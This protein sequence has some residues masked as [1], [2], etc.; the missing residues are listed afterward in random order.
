[1]RLARGSG[2]LLG[3]FAIRRAGRKAGRRAGRQAGSPTCRSHKANHASCPLQPTNYLPTSTALHSLPVASLLP[4]RSPTACRRL[5]YHPVLPVGLGC[6][7]RAPRHRRLG[8]QCGC[9][10]GGL[11]RLLLAWAVAAGAGCWAWPAAWQSWHAPC[12]SATPRF[13]PVLSSSRQC[14][15]ILHTSLCTLLLLLFAS[16][17]HPDLK[18]NTSQ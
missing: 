3:A 4:S 1:V 16:C 17:S 12:H 8:G 14:E 2:G 13:S 11:P 18:P 5:L 9:N 10:S 6:G 7:W 15:S